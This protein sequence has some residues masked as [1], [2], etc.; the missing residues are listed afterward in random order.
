MEKRGRR[1]KERKGAGD[2]WKN[3]RMGAPFPPL[4]PGGESGKSQSSGARNGR[5]HFYV[6]G[7]A[8]LRGAAATER[9]GSD[10]LGF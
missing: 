1:G 2:S 6:D 3:D 5:S 9:E 10:T 8:R 4:Y 7:G